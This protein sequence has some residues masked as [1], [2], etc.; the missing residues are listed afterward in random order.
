MIPATRP[1]ITVLYPEGFFCP[2]CVATVTARLEEHL[3]VDSAEVDFLSAR[4]VITH[5]AATVT[6]EELTAVV[7]EVLAP[8][9]HRATAPAGV[10]DHSAQEFSS[11]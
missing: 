1:R 7:D 3:G 2:S 6:V 10:D 8:E 4:I 5:D 9:D 11:T